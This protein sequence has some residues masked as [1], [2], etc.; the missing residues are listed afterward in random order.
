VSPYDRPV[1]DVPGT[2]PEFMALLR[3]TLSADPAARPQTAAAFRDELVAQ[4]EVLPPTEAA[5][6]SGTRTFRCVASVVGAQSTT[7]AFR[8]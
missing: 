3:R 7:S 8:R 2:P 4:I 5:F 6:D 1:D